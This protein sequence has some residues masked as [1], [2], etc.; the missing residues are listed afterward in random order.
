MKLK[1]IR[2]TFSFD[3]FDDMAVVTF[4][5]IPD[6][7]PYKHY[8]RKDRAVMVISVMDSF[9]SEPEESKILSRMIVATDITV[10]T[11]AFHAKKVLEHY[12]DQ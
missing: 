8:R 12:R 11:V 7:Y 1:G 3:E 10:S 2:S 4:H 6:D 9:H 5:A